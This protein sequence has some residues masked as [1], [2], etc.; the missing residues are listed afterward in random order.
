M[1]KFDMYTDYLPARDEYNKHL[2]E[3]EV[4]SAIAYALRSIY[5]IYSLLPQ[6]RGLFLDIERFRHSMDSVEV[7]LHIKNQV[8][9]NLNS[10]LGEYIPSIEL[11][12]DKDDGILN[13]TVQFYG[14]GEVKIYNGATLLTAVLKYNGK[15]FYD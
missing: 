7:L 2:I 4:T 14:H 9:S 6:L 11:S 12:Y 5:S 8:E 1:A 10:I 3:R 13:Y 15:R